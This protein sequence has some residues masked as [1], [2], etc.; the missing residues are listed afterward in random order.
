MQNS[1]GYLFAVLTMI[2]W[3][4]WT[5][6]SRLGVTSGLTAVDITF[7]RYTCAGLIMLPIAIKHRKLVTRKTILPIIIMI[8]GAGPPYLMA[9]MLGFERAPASHGILIP[10]MMSVCVAVL[11]FL[12]FKEKIKKSRIAGYV[13]IVCG[14]I[15]KMTADPAKISAD[16]F[17]LCG[18]LLW[19]IYSLQ[20]KAL[21]F[22]AFVATAFVASGSMILMI[23][24]YGIYQ[25]Y[26]PH[27]INISDS[28]IQIIY[29]GVI[30]SVISLITYNIALNHIGASR[31]SAC[32]A[33]V[34]VLVTLL[35]IPVL[36]EYPS[37]KDT[38]FVSVMTVGVLLASG[39]TS[40]PKRKTK[41]EK[42]PMAGV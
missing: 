36:G 30:T 7:M 19:S 4:G 2:I 11:S 27:E 3:S 38:I 6:I 42:Q 1:K 10:C 39:I 5:I 12:I 33:L 16:V 32:G 35:A 31:T 37:G 40:L 9:T 28:I 26:N 34:P 21:G 20:N 29:Q 41:A 8:I 17:F 23:I 15:F 18:S 14:V 25:Y 24:P 13:L 22:N